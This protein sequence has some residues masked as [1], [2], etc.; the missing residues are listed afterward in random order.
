MN[1]SNGIIINHNTNNKKLRSFNF[2]TTSIN[3]NK[4]KTKTTVT[5]KIQEVNSI[6]VIKCINNI[7]KNN[8]TDFFIGNLF[9]N[10]SLNKNLL[11]EIYKRIFLSLY[12]PLVTLVSCFLILKSHNEYKYKIFKTKVFLSGTLI[13]IFSQISINL[14]GTNYTYNLISVSFP[15]L[16]FLFIYYY[17]KGFLKHSS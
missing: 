15:I 1:L 7:F 11:Q 10:K 8:E 17:F 12:I 4:Y 13:V 14:I 5:P 3:L 2:E 6:N 9:C 16:V